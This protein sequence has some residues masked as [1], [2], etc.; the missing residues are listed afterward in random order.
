LAGR[1][2][3]FGQV[4]ARAAALPLRERRRGMERGG[5]G[6]GEPE[7]LEQPTAR[8]PAAIEFVEQRLQF[9]THE[10]GPPE[11]RVYRRQRVCGRPGTATGPDAFTAVQMRRPTLSASAT[12]RVSSTVRTLRSRITKRPSIITDSISAG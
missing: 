1:R 9:I 11:C 10:S 7:R 3:A 4:R 6:S 8:Q 2:I 12:I 5:T